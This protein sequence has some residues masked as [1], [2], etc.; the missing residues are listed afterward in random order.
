VA[1]VFVVTPAAVTA[2][3]AAGVRCPGSI[4]VGRRSGIELRAVD[5]RARGLTCSQARGIV[6]AF[7]RKKLADRSERCAANASTPAFPGC[8]VGAYLCRATAV[9]KR[10]GSGPE[11]CGSTEGDVVNFSETDFDH[12]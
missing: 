7:L 2:L 12:G 4:S 6:R 9:P 8:R 1:V 11:V 10:S 3:G 5:L